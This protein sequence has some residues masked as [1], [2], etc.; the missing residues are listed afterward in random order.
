MDYI[1]KSISNAKEMIERKPNQSTVDYKIYGVLTDCETTI[2]A[3][4][5]AINGFMANATSVVRCKDCIF[6]EKSIKG[7]GYCFGTCD[8]L[9]SVD[10]DWF[11]ADGEKE[12]NKE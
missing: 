8:G 12:D 9:G 6:H 5:K 3:L 4:H 1:F 2:K 7:K 11:C 10:D